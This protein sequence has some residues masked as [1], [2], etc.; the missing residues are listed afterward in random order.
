MSIA[1]KTNRSEPE[2]LNSTNEFED[3]DV[4]EIIEANS[5]EL[6]PQS[7]SILKM[8]ART[9]KKRHSQL[10]HESMLSGR[11]KSRYKLA[12]TSER[13][14]NLGE[15]DQSKRTISAKKFQREVYSQMM[16]K[17]FHKQSK[18]NEMK[19]NKYKR[20]L[21]EV[22][23]DKPVVDREKKWNDFLKRMESTVKKKRQRS[24]S[25]AK[26]KRE[27]ILNSGLDDCTFQPNSSRRSQ[28]SQSK[29]KR[30]LKECQEHVQRLYKWQKDLDA[31]K[32]DMINQNIERIR[33]RGLQ[34]DNEYLESLNSHHSER[35]VPEQHSLV[36]EFTEEE[37]IPTGRVEDKT[38]VA[39][40]E[41]SLESHPRNQNNSYWNDDE[42]EIERI[43]KKSKGSAAQTSKSRNR[44]EE[45]TPSDE[46]KKRKMGTSQQR[47]SNNQSF[48]QI[49]SRLAENN[50]QS[51]CDSF[52]AL[53]SHFQDQKGRNSNQLSKNSIH[54]PMSS[55]KR[56][57]IAKNTQPE[58]Q[59]EIGLNS[60]DLEFYSGKTQ[61]KLQHR[62]MKHYETT[63]KK[64]KTLEFKRLEKRSKENQRKRKNPPQSP[65]SGLATSNQKKSSLVQNAMIDDVSNKAS[66]ETSR[67]GNILT[68]DELEE[69]ALNESENDLK[70]KTRQ[71]GYEDKLNQR[72]RFFSDQ[73]RE[74]EEM[75]KSLQLI[76]K[77]YSIHK[78]SEKKPK[79]RNESIREKET[80]SRSF[81]ESKKKHKVQQH[82]LNEKLS[83]KPQNYDKNLSVASNEKRVQDKGLSKFVDHSRSSLKCEEKSE[84]PAVVTTEK[85][86]FRRE[87]KIKRDS[88]RSIAQDKNISVSK[89][90]NSQRPQRKKRISSNLSRDHL[91]TTP[92]RKRMRFDYLRNS[93][94]EEQPNSS[95]DCQP[96]DQRMYQSYQYPLSGERGRIQD[97]ILLHQETGIA[98]PHSP[99]GPIQNSNEVKNINMDKEA[100]FYPGEITNSPESQEHQ[101]IDTNP[102]NKAEAGNYNQPVKRSGSRMRQS[103]V[104]GKI[105]DS[106]YKRKRSRNLSTKVNKSSKVVRLPKDS[107]GEYFNASQISKAYQK[108]LAMINKGRPDNKPRYSSQSSRNESRGLS[109][110]SKRNLENRQLFVEEKRV[111]RV[112]DQILGRNQKNKKKRK[113][114]QFI[115]YKAPN[116]DV[117]TVWKI[118]GDIASE[119]AI[120]VTVRPRWVRK[121][122]QGYDFGLRES[123]GSR[124]RFSPQRDD[125]YLGVEGHGKGPWKV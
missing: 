64:P 48:L 101:L 7:K 3:D 95:R 20:M 9:R 89:Q 4:I 40:E 44:F 63:Q 94:F 21:L 1:T 116:Q 115:K 29:S 100:H 77:R 124:N 80:Q 57:K 50:N 121:N 117:K 37:T 104:I 61:K 83:K 79:Q 17:E 35:E 32:F 103:G 16:K 105:Y 36:V 52:I 87:G 5:K 67:N 28:K 8:K 76:K 15:P 68:L 66:K 71:V 23:D 96:I 56:R 93:E 30:S 41:A 38:K 114:G 73:K 47:I 51:C 65:P 108:K 122:A 55:Q 13:T 25:F 33:G 91:R 34:L 70:R 46:F 43:S 62:S 90:K 112:E 118:K 78:N 84:Q 39:L 81:R 58:L 24:N 75:E 120:G 113:R 2:L 42:S 119:G 45:R 10:K 107:E 111:K 49:P 85:L 14:F 22:K 106:V 99:T 18:I 92:P 72:D 97:S 110:E 59:N 74:R 53:D 19:F 86:E 60:Q 69:L 109:R 82:R 31:R 54:Q 6:N 125:L 11:R 12:P 88:R 26:E 102:I 27:R 123:S 98:E